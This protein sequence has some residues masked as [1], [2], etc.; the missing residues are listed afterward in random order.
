MW[1]IVPLTAAYALVA[2]FS[3]RFRR[4]Y[5][6]IVNAPVTLRP[7]D[8]ELTLYEVAY[9]GFRHRQVA[10][11]ALAAMALSGRLEAK[12]EVL[13]ITDP[14]PRDDIEAEV[15][16]VMGLAP[17]RESWE[18]MH[19]FDKSA[20][21]NAV[22]DRLAGQGLIGSPTLHGAAERARGHLVGI[23]NLAW[24]LGAVATGLAVPEPGSCLVP[25]GATLLLL[26]VGMWRLNPEPYR[27][28]SLT[29]AGPAALKDHEARHPCWAPR[30]HDDLSDEDAVLLGIVARRGSF[31]DRLVPLDRAVDRPVSHRMTEDIREAPGLGGGI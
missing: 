30:S 6:R 26:V 24:I 31:R 13:T 2:A 10:R 20:V 29:D 9:L 25:I 1:W 18:R 15:V 27:S 3:V 7:P 4:R 21:I 5:R 14:V 17:R 8:E 22:G 12:D 28:S 11:T 16:K 23:L 19:R